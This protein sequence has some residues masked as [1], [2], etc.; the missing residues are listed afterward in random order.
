MKEKSCPTLC[1]PVIG[2]YQAPLSMRVSRQEYRSGLPCP[3]P[4]CFRSVSAAE[5]AACPTNLFSL[6]FLG[7]DTPVLFRQGCAKLLQSC[8]TLCDTTDYHPPPP[9]FLC[10]WDSPG[11]NTGVGCHAFLPGI[12]LT[13]GLK[14][15]LPLMPPAL[16]GRLF[17]ASAIWSPIDRDISS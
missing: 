13:Q 8:L 12:F 2:A 1:D 17:T 10:L 5:G 14:M 16:A 3:S 7:N 9:R 15:C 6:L 4:I 11:K